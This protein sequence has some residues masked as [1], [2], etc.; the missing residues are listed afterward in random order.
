MTNNTKKEVI[1][2][3]V[4][5]VA[6]AIILSSFAPMLYSTMINIALKDLI[7]A[8]HTTL[9]LAQWGVT[10]YTLALTVAV[11]ISGWLLDHFD[12]KKIALISI[13]IFGVFSLLCGFAWNISSFILFRILQGFSAGLNVTVGMSILMEVA[14]EG[15]LGRLMALI[16]IPM[17]FG[18]IIGPVIAGLLLQIAN[19]R[20]I[21]FIG[22]IF[23]F[24]AI[25]MIVRVV[26]D[27]QPF[28]PQNKLDFVGI[29]LLALT[30]ASFIFG[31]MQGANSSKFFNQSMFGFVGTGIF[32]LLI[33]GFWNRYKNN[34]TVLPL[35]FFRSSHFSAAMAGMFL[36]AIV[37]N[38]PLLLLPLFFENVN[39]FTPTQA[40]L[41]LI[42]Q[43]I[44][45]LLA[46]PI[47][48]RV[49]DTI[50]SRLVTFVSLTI[51][52]IGSIPF[53]FADAN[54]SIFWLSIVLFIR[55]IGVSGIQLPMMTDIYLGM[56][57]KD[58]PAASVGN[59]MI[60]NVGSSFGTAVMTAVVTAV[61]N[62]Q[63]KVPNSIANLHGYQMAFLVS[64]ITIFI[65][66]IPAIFLSHKT[67]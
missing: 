27:F 45:M 21:F 66:I 14:P 11:P 63:I 58:I 9:P 50:G 28:N 65:M 19:W 59:Q 48:G 8:L 43:G 30:A 22:L 6:F 39:G 29:I 42:P 44:G 49:I 31:L 3:Q 61:V 1:P 54:T 57:P 10:G 62:I 13:I 34:Q 67:A 17:I 37:I 15:V 46:R 26:P 35:R 4:T 23:V 24:A 20:W 40:A 16:T 12:A 18:P 36:S 64:V 41:L 7:T 53:I 33:Y 25:P 60:Q 32:L 5:Q 56:K 2:K 47:V 38:G 51:T 52:L 55:G